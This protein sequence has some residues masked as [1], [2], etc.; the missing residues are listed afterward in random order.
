MS[1]AD[2]F[3]EHSRTSCSDQDPCNADPQGHG[4][5]RCNALLFDRH[6]KLLAD[7]VAHLERAE[8]WKAIAINLHDHRDFVRNLDRAG[9]E[10]AI[11]A[12][13]RFSP[14]LAALYTAMLQEHP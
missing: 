5:W 11:R 9:L 3:P 7:A 1:H 4:C 8:K 14:R 6:D 2:E 10:E 12:T 13:E